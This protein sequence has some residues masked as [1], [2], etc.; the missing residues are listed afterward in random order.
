VNRFEEGAVNDEVDEE[1]EIADEE[2]NNDGSV[3]KST[4]KSKKQKD[5]VS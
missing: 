2:G 4:P 5:I 1:E 3:V